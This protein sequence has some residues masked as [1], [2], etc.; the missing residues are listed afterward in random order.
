MSRTSIRNK[1]ILSF[2]VLLLLLMTVVAVIN[3]LTDDYYT[4]Q[5]ISVALALAAGAIFGGYFSRSIVR[6]LNS[7][8]AVAR[9]VSH[10][11][12]SKDIPLLSQD[13]IRDLEEVFASMVKDLRK[14]ISEIKNVASK[15]EETNRTLSSLSEKVLASSEEIDESAT[16]IAKGSEQQTMIVQKTSLI[17]N[18]CLD[19]MDA[20]GRQSAQTVSKINNALVKTGTGETKA[21]QTLGY[22]D[23][24]LRQIVENTKPI[25]R[26]SN[27]VD[28]I[29]MVMHV[30][31][32]VAQKT[33][34]LSL[35]ASIEATRAGEM[36][37]GFALVANEI[38]SMA[39]NSK[40]SSWEIRRIVDDIFQD[41]KAVILALRKSEDDVGRGRG[42][43]GSMV[44]TF[45]EMVSGVK[46]ISSEVQL[47]EKATLK[48]VKEIRGL[49]SH[50]EALSRL[51][52]QNF[53]ST[54][55]TTVGTRNQKEG[56]RKIVELMQ[57][58]NA[59]SER[60]MASQERFRLRGD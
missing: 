2:L 30:M 10:G 7:L 18:N 60:M 40:Q 12:L 37:K 45:R 46:E 26:L 17:L 25:Y 14:M 39:E 8:S 42:I 27:N 3:R 36:G 32:E 19:Q 49:L 9:E 59:L 57:S 4:A 16:V 54:Q 33:E 55:K 47:V 48:Q 35:N 20:A 58:L 22:L 13:E 53:V 41:N 24:V 1:L 52:Q 50:F 31:D 43:I 44:G 5:A 28:K 21:R 11:D 29:R 38:R 23:N 15:M 51:A 6:R 56:M 34:L